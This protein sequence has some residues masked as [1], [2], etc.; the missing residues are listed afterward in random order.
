M[1]G[2]TTRPRIRE[3][4]GGEDSLMFGLFRRD[5]LQKLKKEYEGKLRQARDLQR[6]GDVRGAAALVA[7]A[8]EIARCL[9][10]MEK[11]PQGEVPRS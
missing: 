2:S 10:E 6:N 3:P 8:E 1:S 4:G 11:S 5:P 9:E 7:E